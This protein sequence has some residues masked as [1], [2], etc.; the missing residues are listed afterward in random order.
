[1]KS[2]IQTEKDHCYLCKRNA[3]FEPLDEHHVFFGPYR[4][5]S[6]KYGL[7]VYLHHQTCH[8]GGVHKNA[9]ICRMIQKAAQEAAMEC[10]GWTECEF[11]SIFGRSYL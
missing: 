2:V 11:R 10:Y 7:K 9:E 4:A 8:L 3:S 5:K 6:E 1:M